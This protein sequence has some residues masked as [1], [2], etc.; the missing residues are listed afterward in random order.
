MAVYSRRS[1]RHNGFT[2][3]NHALKIPSKRKVSFRRTADPAQN[4]PGTN[5]FNGHVMARNERF[6]T[7]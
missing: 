5:L 7:G 2:Q 1:L 6:H 4:P 3:F